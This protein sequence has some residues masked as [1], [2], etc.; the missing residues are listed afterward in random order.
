MIKGNNFSILH[1]PIIS[2]FYRRILVNFTI[3]FKEVF[4][5]I[6]L[7]FVY[8]KTCR[9]SPLPPEAQKNARTG[10]EIA[11]PRPGR[12]FTGTVLKIIRGLLSLHEGNRQ[13][14]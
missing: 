9:K 1:A 7:F 11:A 4:S 2:H 12:S 3:N 5:D 8:T 14:A 6:F 10:F 13:T